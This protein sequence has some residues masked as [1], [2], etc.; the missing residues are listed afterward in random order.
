MQ[1]EGTI[2]RLIII[3]RQVNHCQ[4]WNMTY[5][6]CTYSHGLRAWCE[7]RA[8]ELVARWNCSCEIIRQLVFNVSFIQL[9]I[10]SVASSKR[11]QKRYE[12]SCPHSYLTSK[13]VILA[14]TVVLQRQ[15]KST[16]LMLACAMMCFIRRGAPRDL[17]FEASQR[18][19][20]IF[21]S[22]IG[23]ESGRVRRD[24]R[25]PDGG[26]SRRAR[27]LSTRISPAFRRAGVEPRYRNLP[28]TKPRVRNGGE[29]RGGPT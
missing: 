29:N 10:P 8:G 9:I 2:I 19:V 18:A 12:I 27:C 25:V 28:F 21:W 6:S 11:P 16:C 20:G 15:G 1:T 24:V 22:W 17:R 23:H 4:L 14:F 5:M 7:E 26:Y 3:P 13:D